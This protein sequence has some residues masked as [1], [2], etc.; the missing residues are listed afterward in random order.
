M[1]RAPNHGLQSLLRAA[2][3]G[4][5][6]LAQAIRV[7]AAEDGTTLTCH[8]TTVRRW[9]S[10]TRPRP[11][12]PV[13][14]LECLSRR[15][16]R[17]VTA[18]EAGLSSAPVVIA[19]SSWTADPVHRLA[20]LTRAEI[21]PNQPDAEG[22]DIFT[23]AA[24]TPPPY[25]WPL[26]AEFPLRGAS[27][28][29]DGMTDM[30]ELFA[31][32]ADQHGGQ[33]T[34]VALSAF[35]AHE[36]LP[37]LN[38]PVRPPGRPALFSAAARLTLLLGNMSIDSGHH[39]T[40]QHYHQVAA[41]LAAE[42]GDEAA[43]AISL[44]SMATHAYSRGHHTPAVLHLADRADRQAP[45]AVRA[46]TQAQLAVILAHHDRSAAMSTLSRAERS[47]SRVPQAGRGEGPFDSY[48]T[49]ALYYQRAETLVVLGD[50]EGAASAL[51]TSMRLRAPSEKLPGALT[52]AK[53]AEINC[54]TGK[55]D[56]AVEH[57][58]IFL[59]HYPGFRSTKATKVIHTAH[60]LLRPYARYRPA[61]DLTQRMR[62][63]LAAPS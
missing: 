19:G 10:G 9:L 4:P 33:H 58:G 21:D 2:E 36:V 13:L 46:Y 28:E 18:Q 42:A 17:R 60:H 8:H 31:A 56:Q 34:I 47:H 6:Q 38:A 45:P 14:I 26:H 15:L 37:R 35:V 43:L 5:V 1:T 22:S 41:R 53:L 59:Q 48:P 63:I 11:P 24:L 32:A 39:T 57:W 30:G 50:H 3:W 16:G 25:D 51:T 40:A 49:S 44:R 27:A 23:L 7:L 54:V 12:Y 61:A 62:S 29:A 52:R 20:Q 55:I